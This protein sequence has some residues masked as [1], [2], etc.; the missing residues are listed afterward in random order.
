MD[1]FKGLRPVI[2]LIEEASLLSFELK[3]LLLVRSAAKDKFKVVRIEHLDRFDL[4]L[5][6]KS[7][8]L[9][10]RCL[11]VGKQSSVQSK[12]LFLSKLLG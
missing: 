7:S 5:K 3:K 9:G 2:I 11:L 8:S 12:A 10:G 4:Q 6:L 1:K